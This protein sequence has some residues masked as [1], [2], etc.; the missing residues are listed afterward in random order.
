MTATAALFWGFAEATLFFVVPDVFL[1]LMAARQGARRLL[2]LC[3][4]SAFGALLGGS[5]MMWWGAH[6]IAT[7]RAAVSHLPAI[8]AAMIAGT[9][10]AMSQPSWPLA[11]LLGAF[12]GIPYKVFAMEAGAAGLSLAP[13]LAA[14]FVVRFA[15]FCL[16]V[17]LVRLAVRFLAGRFSPSLLTLALAGLWAA[18]YALFWSLMPS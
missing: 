9:A 10:A 3:A 7:A 14:S 11:M 18:F 13:F 17:L 15:R 8:S 2:W 5:A 1:T 16:A 4:S 12:G 6:D